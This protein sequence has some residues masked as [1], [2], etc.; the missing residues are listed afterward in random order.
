MTLQQV[1]LP[2]R[3]RTVLPPVPGCMVAAEEQLSQL[4]QSPL[5]ARESLRSYGA[6]WSL[7][8]YKYSGYAGSYLDLPR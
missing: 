3:F 1:V 4:A 8:H 6:N 7:V 2:R 5:L